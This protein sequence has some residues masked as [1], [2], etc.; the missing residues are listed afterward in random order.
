MISFKSLFCRGF[1]ITVW[2]VATFILLYDENVAYRVQVQ[3]QGLVASVHQPITKPEKEVNEPQTVQLHQIYYG[4]ETDVPSASTGVCLHS[5]HRTIYNRTETWLTQMRRQNH[6]RNICMNYYN[7]TPLDV[8]RNSSKVLDILET[9]LRWTYFNDDFKFMLSFIHKIGSSNW[10]RVFETLHNKSSI[11]LKSQQK[12][13]LD[14]LVGKRFD[15][16]PQQ[17]ID[18]L[19]KFTKVIF[20]RHPL[21]RVLSAYKDKL[22]NLP[23]S[24]YKKKARLILEV[25]RM[26]KFGKRKKPNVTFTEFIHFITNEKLGFL[27]RDNHWSAIVDRYRPCEYYFDFIGH[28]ETLDED[29]NY[30]FQLLNI[31]DIV[32]FELSKNPTYSSSKLGLQEYFGELS[33]ELFQKVVMKYEHDFRVFGYHI[34]LNVSDI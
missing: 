27:S 15:K 2:I 6:I 7:I 5:N 16:A 22:V 30:L 11:K 3:V 8:E 34:P 1:I 10:R 13:P 29:V 19:S 14:T 25:E 9:R 17:I 33:D 28:L 23:T 31:D 32:S 4:K 20:V 21:A 18:R 26:A 24:W 12:D